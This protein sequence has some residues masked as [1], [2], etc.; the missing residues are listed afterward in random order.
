MYKN[1]I[2]LEDIYIYIYIN[3][4]THHSMITLSCTRKLRKLKSLYFY[5]ALDIIK[6]CSMLMVAFQ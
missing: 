6:V 3:D 2:K 4:S 1:L 5:L